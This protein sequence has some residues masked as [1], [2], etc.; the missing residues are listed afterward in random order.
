MSGD[1][2]GSPV[3]LTQQGHSLGTVFS[4]PSFRFVS[5]CLPAVRII[6]PFLV[7]LSITVYSQSMSSEWVC[8]YCYSAIASHCVVLP[9]VVALGSGGRRQYLP[10]E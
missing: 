6:I 9:F 8:C 2:L 10:W 3:L 7:Y 4:N 5:V 1:T